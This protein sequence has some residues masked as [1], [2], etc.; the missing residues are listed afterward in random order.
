MHR[1]VRFV[2]DPQE[3]EFNALTGMLADNAL[4]PEALLTRVFDLGDEGEISMKG[5]TPKDV[6]D[7][8]QEFGAN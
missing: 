1:S 2:Y 8:R 7:R 4:S 6:S 3:D 5:L